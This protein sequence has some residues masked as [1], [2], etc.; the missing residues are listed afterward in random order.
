MRSTTEVSGLA[1]AL[2]AQ[3]RGSARREGLELAV[4]ISG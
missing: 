2:G 4:R 3:L 1:A